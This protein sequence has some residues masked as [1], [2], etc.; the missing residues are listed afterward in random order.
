MHVPELYDAVPSTTNGQVLP[1]HIPL[2]MLNK[3]PLS[4]KDASLYEIPLQT[5][6]RT[7]GEQTGNINMNDSSI[8]ETVFDDNYEDCTA[9]LPVSTIISLKQYYIHLMHTIASNHYRRYRKLF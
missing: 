8:H 3:Q 4:I 5:I 1:N 2:E 7:T 6:K 9:E